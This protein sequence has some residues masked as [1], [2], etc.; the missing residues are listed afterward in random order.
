MPLKENYFMVILIGFQKIAVINVLNLPDS[1]IPS[2]FIEQDYR[3]HPSL[4]LGDTFSPSL[5]P[6][7]NQD[8]MIKTNFQSELIVLD[9]SRGKKYYVGVKLG[10]RNLLDVSGKYSVVFSSCHS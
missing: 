2:F 7:I 10:W 3:S 5:D 1:A 8:K 4:C 6:V 9:K